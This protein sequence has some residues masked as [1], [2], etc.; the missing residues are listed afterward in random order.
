MV[1]QLS[2]EHALES[3][4]SLLKDKTTGPHSQNLFNKSEVRPKNMLF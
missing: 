4:G 1:N 3:L 2:N